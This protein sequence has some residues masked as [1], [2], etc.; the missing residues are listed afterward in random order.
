MNRPTYQGK[1]RKRDDEASSHGSASVERQE[2]LAYFSGSGWRSLDQHGN[3]SSFQPNFGPGQL[4]RELVDRAHVATK[5]SPSIFDRPPWFFWQRFEDHYR[6]YTKDLGLYSKVSAL[7]S[8]F[9][10]GEKAP[11][12]KRQQTSQL[13]LADGSAP[14]GPSGYSAARTIRPFRPGRLPGSDLNRLPA[15]VPETLT[16]SQNL[17]N[18]APSRWPD[19]S[20]HL[21]EQSRVSTLG[22][23]Q[24]TPAVGHGHY[25]GLRT[26]T[27]QP[28]TLGAAQRKGAYHRPSASEYYDS[29]TQS[30]ANPNSNPNRYHQHAT[31]THPDQNSTLPNG[32]WSLQQ[33]LVPYPV[34]AT[35]LPRSSAPNPAPSSLSSLSSA[36]KP[37]V[38]RV[39]AKKHFQGFL[40]VREPLPGDWQTLDIPQLV[41]HYPNH[42][43][44]HVLRHLDKNDFHSGR[45]KS[46]MHPHAASQLSSSDASYLRR[47]FINEREVEEQEKRGV[48][49]QGLGFTVGHQLHPLPGWY[50]AAPQGHVDQRHQTAQPAAQ[51]AEQV[52]PHNGQPNSHHSPAKPAD[53]DTGS[54]RAVSVDGNHQRLVIEHRLQQWSATGIQWPTTL[55]AMDPE[56]V[57]ELIE[58]SLLLLDSNENSR[59]QLPG[60]P[61]GALR[62]SSDTDESTAVED[63]SNLDPALRLGENVH[64]S[65]YAPPAGGFD[66]NH[67]DET[68]TQSPNGDK[69]SLDGSSSQSPTLKGPMVNNIDEVN[70]TQ[71]ANNTDGQSSTG[72]GNLVNDQQAALPINDGANNDFDFDELLTFDDIEDESMLQQSWEMLETFIDPQSL[73]AVHEEL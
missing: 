17:T 36:S 66:A 34:A 10:G 69:A 33:P 28:T 53:A 62:S 58:S 13:S 40:S 39:R 71:L 14:D 67:S 48:P 43:V 1:K 3:L 18:A 65:H 19:E 5:V 23:T 38:R 29:T 20:H 54:Q 56:K 70:S 7:P 55:Q 51:R 31:T 27:P 57:L 15:E 22:H 8:N 64:E 42:L 60:S 52:L 37:L 47:R 11:P 30:I 49:P 41:Y 25:Q 21:H 72:V 73:S 12:P 63:F 59:Q 32:E 44:G 16:Y 6:V 24:N 4:P 50:T 46:A 9:F 26:T 68:C 35:S 2:T 61:P 45:V